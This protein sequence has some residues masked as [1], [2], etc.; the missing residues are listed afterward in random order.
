MRKMNAIDVFTAKTVAAGATENSEI[1]NIERYDNFALH[2]E[3]LTGG[4]TPNVDL[5][6]T[7]CRTESG[8]FLTPSANNL[9]A[10]DLKDEDAISFS[11][12]PTKFIKIHCL[13][14]DVADI[15]ITA[16]IICQEVS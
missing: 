16:K 4:G 12:V 5:S 14:N 15:V 2:V 8:T 7:V 1:I 6:Y 3:S 13:N 10:N 9:I 11:P